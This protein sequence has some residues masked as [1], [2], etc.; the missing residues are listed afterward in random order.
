MCASAHASRVMCMWHVCPCCRAAGVL[1]AWTSL[2]RF[3]K[4]I[5]RACGARVRAVEPL[6]CHV[7]A[8]ASLRRCHK[9][10]CSGG[11]C[12][13]CVCVCMCM[14]TRRCVCS[15][16]RQVPPQVRV[17]DVHASWMRILD[18]CILAAHHD[19]ASWMRI[20]DARIL[21]AHRIRGSSGC[22]DLWCVARTR[23]AS[24][25]VGECVQRACVSAC[26]EGCRGRDVA[27]YES[28]YPR[29]H[30]CTLTYMGARSVRY[31]TCC[32]T[33][34]RHRC[35]RWLRGACRVPIGA[36]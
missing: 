22:V 4:C 5:A 16:R 6:V 31:C 28:C 7:H 30:R 10:A 19:C 12:G 33:S 9:C 21:D 34:T 24:C 26:V 3:C 8:R 27:R 13:V 17:S 29:P 2:R 14:L 23:R 36:W 15:A 25:H 18:A 11:V 1:R 20:S 35:S 32:I